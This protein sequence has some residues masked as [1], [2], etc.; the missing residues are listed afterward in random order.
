VTPVATG[1][2]KTER[3]AGEYPWRNAFVER[4]TGREVEMVGMRRSL[5]GPIYFAWVDTGERAQ[6]S[7][8]EFYE[9]FEETEWRPT[10]PPREGV[11]WRIYTVQ[12]GRIIGYREVPPRPTSP[13]A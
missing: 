2:R 12:S 5:R 1:P 6:L 3:R 13:E 10:P 8:P 11:W 9:R 7:A 4:A